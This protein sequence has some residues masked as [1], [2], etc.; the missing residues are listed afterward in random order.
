MNIISIISTKGGVGKTTLTANLSGYLSGINY[1]VL[2]IDAD[3]QPSLSSYYQISD[4]A[5][6]GLTEFLTHPEN[7][8]DCI[9]KTN[10]KNL[11]LVYSNDHDNQ[12]Q[13]WLVGKGDGRFRLKVAINALT[14]KYD[15]V[16]IDTQGAKGNLQDA[17]VLAANILISPMPPEMAAVKELE[18]G[19]LSMLSDL[20]SYKDMG[21]NVPDLFSV[22]YKM[23][24]TKDA[25]QLVEYLES[26]SKS[27]PYTMLNTQIPQSV[28][29]R[30]AT[31]R[32]MPVTEF[33]NSNKKQQK[34]AE[35]SIASII[36]LS[37]EIKKL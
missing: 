12:L 14:E 9:S 1:K 11:D 30:E 32:Q 15:Y 22:V 18:R 25:Q 31:S 19:T 35:K 34:K 37:K 33:E 21:I 28:V 16:I 29:F 4:Q 10:Y 3:P 27:K 2:M 26:S 17:A 36:S 5:L 13:A 24:R 23:D 7:A 8:D 6:G 20:Q